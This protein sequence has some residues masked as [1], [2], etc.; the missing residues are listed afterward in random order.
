M[1]PGFPARPGRNTGVVRPRRHPPREVEQRQVSIRVRS[2]LMVIGF[3]LATAA[4]LQVLSIARHVIVWILIALFLTLALNPAVEWF[5]RHGVKSRGL[6]AGLTYV[7]AL[8]AIA[9]I[10]ALFIP[11]LVSQ[12]NDLVNK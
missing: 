7:V 10:G 8:A 12:V 11:T 5:M 6:A 2:V 3:V 9:G 4:L 1:R